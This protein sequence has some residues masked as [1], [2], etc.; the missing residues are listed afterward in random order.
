MADVEDKEDPTSTRKRL[1]DIE[2]RYKGQNTSEHRQK[3]FH[4][5]PHIDHN[6]ENEV[7]QIQHKVNPTAQKTTPHTPLRKEW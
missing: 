3:W 5:I 7:Q 2:H 6:T 4:H 1:N